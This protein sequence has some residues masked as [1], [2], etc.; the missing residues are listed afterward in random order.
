M[1]S[2]SRSRD[3]SA[4]IEQLSEELFTEKAI[5]FSLQ[6]LPDSVSTKEEKEA[7]KLK[8]SKLQ[9]KIAEARGKTKAGKFGSFTWAPKYDTAD[10]TFSPP[11]SCFCHKSEDG[12]HVI[13][14]HKP[15]KSPPPPKKKPLRS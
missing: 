8:I 2:S 14:K 3:N 9:R 4:I 1:A 6:D 15:L 11:T 13:G 7:V 12:R 10:R 5:L